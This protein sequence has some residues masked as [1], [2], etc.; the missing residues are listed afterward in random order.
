MVQVSIV[1]VTYNSG[2]VIVESLNSIYQ[3]A[4][5]VDLEII[6][7][8]NNSQ[9]NTISSVESISKDIIIIKNKENKGF[10]SANNQ[11]FKIARGNI[12]LI[13][14]PDIVISSNT[15]LLALSQK[16]INES[17]IGV[18]APRLYYPNGVIQESARG[19][20]NPL[21]QLGRGL[22]LEKYLKSFRFYKKFIID[23]N[24]ITDDVNVD[25]VIGA[26]MLLRKEVLVSVNYFDSSYFMYY[27]D[28]DLC[29]K[30]KKLGFNI[31]YTPQFS[32][33]HKYQRESSKRIF[34]KTKGYHIVSILR[35]YSK[36]F[37]HLLFK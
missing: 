3:F 5:D 31:R 4:K 29:L 17:D 25:W 19:F 2:R 18:L 24:A 16:L 20:P 33:T 35:F 23:V 12:I 13:L 10:A 1:I 8:D 30:L 9:D 11:A 15:N 21:A 27:E 37:L 28:A 6:I 7:V 14:N 34:S 26:F 22:K 36:H 32:A